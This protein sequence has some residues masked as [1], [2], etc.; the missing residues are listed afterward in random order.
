MNLKMYVF[1]EDE[2]VVTWIAAENKE[3]AINI[4][5]HIT[6]VNIKIEVENPNEY[7]REASPGETMNYYH[8]GTTRETDTMENLINKYCTEP[9]IFATSE[10]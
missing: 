8:D 4:F 9:D 2:G 1:G 3:Q 5:E 10:F 7:V 6:D